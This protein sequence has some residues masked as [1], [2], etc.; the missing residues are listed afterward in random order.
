MEVRVAG[1]FHHVVDLH[2]LADQLFL[3]DAFEAER[4][5]IFQFRTIDQEEQRVVFICS[6]QLLC[7][8]QFDKCIVE[9]LPFEKDTGFCDIIENCRLYVLFFPQ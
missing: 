4:A 6:G 7:F 1:I 2:L 3:A 5:Q 9:K 8:F